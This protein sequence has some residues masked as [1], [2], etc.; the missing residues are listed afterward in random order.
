MIFEEKSSQPLLQLPV[1]II[2]AMESIKLLGKR[3]QQTV[4]LSKGRMGFT[5]RCQT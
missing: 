5:L 3:T 4:I 2:A 1:T